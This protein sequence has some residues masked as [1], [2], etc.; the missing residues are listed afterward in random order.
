MSRRFT[1]AR[2]LMADLLDRHEAGAERPIGYPDYGRFVDVV[3]M[4]KFTKELCEAEEQRAIKITRERGLKSDQIKHVRLEEPAL[5]YAMLKRRPVGELTDEATGRLL[6]GLELPVQF[7]GSLATLRAAW[8]RGREWQGFSLGDVDRLRPAF[9]MAKAI[10]EYRHAGLDYRTFSRRFS[11]DSKALERLEGPVVRILSGALELPPTAR[12]RD[13]LR[14]LGL[15]KFAPPMLLS[16]RLDFDM[17]EL[18][19]A[20]PLYFG[21]PPAEATRLRFRGQPRYVLTIENF[22]SFH[23]HVAE[24]DPQR[25]GVTIYVGGY[26][27]L[28]TQGALK[29]L[30]ASLPADVPFFHWSDIDPDGVWIFRTIE[31]SLARELRPHLM[32]VAIAKKLGKPPA[33]RVRLPSDVGSSAIADLAAYLRHPGA[34]WLEQEELDP[35]QP[36][37]QD[38]LRQEEEINVV[39]RQD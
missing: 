9:V 12:P 8:S 18:S 26:P 14:T 38:A 17:A 34:N 23:R 16:G 22:A 37:I 30:A 7:E 35:T 11:G 15:E 25:S 3:Q 21:I 24:A 5:L 27:S 39:G 4:D 20:A 32:S 28:A 2:A 10:L 13:A 1:D 6:Q 31:S 29:A 36:E 19:A 33:D